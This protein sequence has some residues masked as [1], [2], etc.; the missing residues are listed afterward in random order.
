MQFPH[1][2]SDQAL[3][4][5]TK[6]RLSW[7]PPFDGYS[8]ILASP[9]DARS[10]LYALGVTFHQMLTGRLPFTAADPMESVHCHIAKKPA[11]PAERLESVPA[12]I[13]EIVMKLLA[14]TA[15]D[16]Y[17]TAAGI[18][19]KSVQED[20]GLVPGTGLTNVKLHASFLSCAGRMRVRRW[21]R[22]S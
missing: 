11:A 2:R 21:L 14:K 9:I 15:E 6:M 4:V 13:S 8:R 7:R 18:P 17:Q 20:G 10:D 16:R 12:V 5:A 3:D 22:R 19:I 1:L